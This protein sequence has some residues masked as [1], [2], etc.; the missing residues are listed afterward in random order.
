MPACRTAGH[1]NGEPKSGRHAGGNVTTIYNNMTPEQIKQV[2]EQVLEALPKSAPAVGPGAE[3]RVGQAVTA[4]GASEGDDGLQQALSLLAAGNVAQ[5]VPLLQAAVDEKTARI[6]QDS[7]V[8][9][10]AY[11]NL[12][13]IAGLA[14][15]E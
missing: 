1:D 4:K 3:Q 6:R 11:R 8:A 9:A 14:D 7:Q 12:G 10:A 15:P 13:A 5:A 2:V